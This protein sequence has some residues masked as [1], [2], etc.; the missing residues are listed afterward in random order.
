MSKTDSDSLQQEQQ[1]EQELQMSPREKLISE[2]ARI[3]WKE[4]EPF[5]AKGSLI[6]VASELDLI[7]AALAISED[8]SQK[9]KAWMDNKQMDKVSTE[10]ALEWLNGEPELWSVVAAPWVLVQERL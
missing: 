9:V 7:D 4:L 2:T 10:Q 3:S 6:W 1:I 5:F 8:D